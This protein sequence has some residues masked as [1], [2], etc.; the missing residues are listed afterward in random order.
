M[1]TVRVTGGSEGTRQSR[2][3]HSLTVKT[4]GDVPSSAAAQTRLG[5]TP[6]R[7]HRSDDE[8]HVD[9][10]W[11]RQNT[12]HSRY[13]E[14]MEGTE[15]GL[16]VRYHNAAALEGVFYYYYYYLFIYLF[17]F[18]WSGAGSGTP[19]RLI[20]SPMTRKR[21]RCSILHPLTPHPPS[22]NNAPGKNSSSGFLPKSSIAS[23]SAWKYDSS[24]F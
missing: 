10:V 1:Q 4:H 8:Q 3:L 14:S 7:R 5:S 15:G 18:G 9:T 6:A 16:C 17:I 12:H 22:Q 2:M 21:T 19:L 13:I 24:N 20:H 23:L 11:H